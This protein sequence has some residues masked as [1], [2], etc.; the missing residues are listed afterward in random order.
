MKLNKYYWVEGYTLVVYIKNCLPHSAVKDKTPYKAFY[1]VKPTISHL[2]P[3]GRTCYV[4]ILKERRPPRSKL[5]PC[6]EKGLFFGY[7]DTPLIYKV[8]IPARQH[9]CTISALNMKFHQ[10]EPN[11]PHSELDSDIKMTDAPVIAPYYLCSLDNN[12]NTAPDT[13]A[14]VIPPL[15]INRLEYQDLDHDDP[16]QFL[17]STAPNIDEEEQEP[18]SYYQAI[19]GPYSALWQAGIK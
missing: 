10:L 5:N 13:T 7:T 4:H 2:Q 11:I 19:N 16:E 12:Q 8:H 9:T 18:N 6:V 3:F 1:G 14:L 15:L 17:L